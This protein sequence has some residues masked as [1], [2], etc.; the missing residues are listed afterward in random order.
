MSRPHTYWLG[1]GSNLGDRKATMCAA[2]DRLTDDGTQIEAVSALYR[3][4][5]RDLVDQPS[6]YNAAVRVRS[7]RP[8]RGLL[9]QIKAMEAQMGR[10]PG[11]VRFGPRVIDCDILAWSGGVWRDAVLEVPHPRLAQ[12][13]FALAP[14]CD[15]NPDLILPAYGSIAAL[16]G[17]IDDDQQPVERLEGGPWWPD[18][19]SS[20]GR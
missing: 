7:P 16:L 9:E 3:T 8:P 4:A 12:R 13:R 18:A 14:L 15:L 11:G 1:L 19:P 10:D 17:A 6:F 5:P 20:G 2:L